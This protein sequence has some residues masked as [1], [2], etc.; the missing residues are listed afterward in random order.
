MIKELVKACH[1]NLDRRE[2]ITQ[3]AMEDW[4]ATDYQVYFNR[5][6]VIFNIVCPA[7]NFK[8]TYCQSINHMKKRNCF[9]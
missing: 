6:K 5:N 4:R 3:F 7:S 1:S 2:P 9:V 8:L